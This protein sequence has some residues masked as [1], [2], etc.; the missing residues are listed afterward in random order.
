VSPR[1]KKTANKIPGKGGLRWYKNVGLGF[2][3]PKEA[4]EGACSWELG[5]A[6][7]AQ[8]QTVLAAAEE[9]RPLQLW[10]LQQLPDRP[11]AMAGRDAAA[12]AQCR[13]QVLPKPAPASC[14]RS[15][16]RTVN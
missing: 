8:Q 4:I 15:C 16:R 2:K 10:F 7:R 1:A 9:L 12:A 11:K 13:T 6:S 14:A 5:V 3:T